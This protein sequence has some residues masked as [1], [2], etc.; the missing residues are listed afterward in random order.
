MNVIVPLKYVPKRLS[1]N[2]KKKQVKMLKKSKKL[3]AQKKYYTREE[4]KSFVS[5]PS[6]HV[7]NTR[8][9]YNIDK[10]K[11]NKELA[12]ATGCSVKSLKQI[13]KKGQGAYYSSGSRPNQTAHSWGIARL[14][15]AIT[16]GKSAIVDFSIIEKGC[17]H[18]KRAYKLAK[19]AKEKGMR[20]PIKIKV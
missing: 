4:V 7:K 10:V 11:P 3:Y 8:S 2:D 18:K 5:K 14:A 19:E 13:V 17:D 9:I 20:K 15:S 1:E 16:S 12:K 6:G